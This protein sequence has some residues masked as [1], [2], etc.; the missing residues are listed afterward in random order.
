[1]FNT[2]RR[3]T[4]L[5]APNERPNLVEFQIAHWHV[6]NPLRQKLFAAFTGEL[7]DVQHGSLLHITKASGSAHTVAFHKAMK[8]HRYLLGW[9]A[10]IFAERLLMRLSEALAALLALVA[11]NPI[12]SIAS[13]F[14][15][16]DPAIVTR[17]CESP[18][19]PQPK[20]SILDLRT[21]TASA[22]RFLIPAEALTSVGIVGEFG[23]PDWNHTSD[24]PGS[25]GSLCSLSYGG[26]GE[27]KADQYWL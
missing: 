5:F 11:L 26:E 20:S 18:C 1:L 10:Y 6:M 23:T 25:N 19:D 27:E 7:Q 21:R 12:L 9:Q 24:L 15:H 14:D 4:F 3:Q 2:L 13:C 17:H 16:F 8:D 22:V